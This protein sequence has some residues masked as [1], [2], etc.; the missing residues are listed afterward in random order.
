MDDCVELS[1]AAA[2]A[3]DELV[4]PV[5][6]VNDPP[7]MAW[8]AKVLCYLPDDEHHFPRGKWAT[9]QHIEA[10]LDACA[11][12]VALEIEKRGGK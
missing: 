9:I 4:C 12:A 11:R 8:L 5:G 7:K 2:D 6:R 10:Q 1:G 3:L